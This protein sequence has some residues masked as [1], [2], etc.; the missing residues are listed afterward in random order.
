MKK[1]TIIISVI[2][3]ILA[4][5]AI[6]L[7][8]NRSETTIS[9]KYSDFSIEDTA[10]VSKIFIADKEDNAV[11]L[12]QSKEGRW[13]VNDKYVVRSDAMDL[14]LNTIHKIEVQRP[15][16][17][18]AH[19]TVVKL[20]AAQSK[21]VEIYQHAYR[22]NLSD[23]F[24]FFPYEK[25]SKTYYVGQATQT[26]T[27]TYMLLE[28][29]EVPFITYIP[30]FRGFLTTRFMTDVAEWRDP[31]IFRKE[32]N[33]IQSVE[34]HFLEKPSQSYKI[35][36]IDDGEFELYA[37]Q[38]N[39]KIAGYDTLRMLDFMTSFSNISFESSLNDK[40]KQA[41]YDSI[42]SSQPFHSI[43]LQGIN[44]EE[45]MV[46]TYHRPA[47]AGETDYEG[48][49]VKYDRDRLYALINDGQDFVLIQFY[50]FDKILHPLSYFRGEK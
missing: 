9:K 40:M 25:L 11:T 27:G 49:P 6:Y 29:S 46:K 50:V 38:N 30:G 4:A 3:L 37:F 43:T 14:L 21:K 35:K 5:I 42:I 10:A 34:M 32:M 47:P 15:V 48:N 16:P 45:Q 23:N 8:S 12:I 44:G 7:T 41:K 31:A 33:E 39:R 17:R 2:A 24:R 19:N 13:E 1:S 18:A 20:L 28:G 26:N 22:I 36:Q